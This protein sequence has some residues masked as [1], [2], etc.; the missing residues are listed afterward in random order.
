MFYSLYVS[1]YKVTPYTKYTV[2]HNYTKRGGKT[3]THTLMTHQLFIE[4]LGIILGT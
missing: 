1:L 3:D 2:S 4:D